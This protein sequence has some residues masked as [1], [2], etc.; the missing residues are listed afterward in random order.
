MVISEDATVEQA[1]CR[2]RRRDASIDVRVLEV[3][4]RHLVERG[5]AALSIAGIAEEAGTTRQALYRRWPTKQG[6]VSAAIRLAAGDATALC[7]EHPRLDL[8]EEL[9]RWIAAP[10]MGGFSLAGAMLQTDTPESARECYREHVIEPRERRLR[11]I[12]ER[13]QELG[14]ADG[15]ADVETAVAMVLGGAYSA[16]LTGKQDADW[17]ARTAALVWRAIGGTEPTRSS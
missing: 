8:E 9:Q 1:R 4:N 17:A 3:T 10:D 14:Q 2:G 15:A 16:Q 11:E 7:V 5:F 6:L 13:A 12:L